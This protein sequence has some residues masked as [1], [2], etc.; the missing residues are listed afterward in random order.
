MSRLRDLITNPTEPAPRPVRRGVG[1]GI[2]ILVAAL[3]G[4]AVVRHATSGGLA[5]SEVEAG[6]DDLAVAVAGDVSKFD[7]AEHH[8][9]DAASVSPLDSYP[10][11]L[12]RSG[13]R[14]A[15]PTGHD[16]QDLIA[17]AVAAN[18]FAQAREQ[19]DR[20]RQT[21][22]SAAELWTRLVDGL[23]LRLH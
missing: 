23:A 10:A 18:D 1:V 12:I 5:R 21:N 19:I 3:L 9:V 11:F 22:A 14:L 13:R 6:L 17:E 7:E 2:V 16:G 20:L 8:F 15:K 4:W